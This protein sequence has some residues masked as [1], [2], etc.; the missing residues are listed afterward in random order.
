MFRST[1]LRSYLVLC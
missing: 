1:P